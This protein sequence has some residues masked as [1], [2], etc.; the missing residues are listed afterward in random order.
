LAYLPINTETHPILEYEY[1]QKLQLKAL[2]KEYISSLRNLETY[3]ALEQIDYYGNSFYEKLKYKISRIPMP[4]YLPILK[5]IPAY[6]NGLIY[7]ET[8]TNTTLAKLCLVPLPYFNSYKHLPDDKDIDISY[9]KVDECYKIIKQDYT[10][11]VAYSDTSPFT[12]AASSQYENHIFKQGD[13]VMEV[14]TQYK[15]NTFAKK[16]FAF[17]LMVHIIYY[18]SYF[19]A[20]S[21]PEELYNYQPGTAVTHPQHIVSI[22]IMM[23][24]GSF[25]LLQ[26]ARQFWINKLEYIGSAYNYI[27]LAAF[28]LP[29]TTLVL[30][31]SNPTHL[32]S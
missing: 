26:E 24:S 29:V 10:K 30:L 28:I 7:G 4:R 15:W 3:S 12:R 9:D 27:D 8:K 25:L 18:I 23:I 13:T 6:I 17:I 1:S 21:F 16:K 20:V 14:L 11:V 19:T 31:T 22:I 5:Y 2:Q 32:V